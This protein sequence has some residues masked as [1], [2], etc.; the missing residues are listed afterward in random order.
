[1]LESFV[2]PTPQEAYKLAL[3]KYG[4]IENFKVVSAKQFKDKE[5][6]LLSEITIEVDEEIY[7]NSIGISQEEELIEEINILRAKMDK[8]K[9]ALMPQEQTLKESIALEEV[10]NILE[11]RGLQRAWIESMLDPFLGTQVAED[12]SLLISFILEEIEDALNIAKEPI[13]NKILMLVGPTGV[14][15]TTT[16]AKIAGWALQKGLDAN[17]AALIN[18]D[19][20]RVGAYEQLE[21]YSKALDIAY[22]TPEDKEQF[23][24]T[25][26]ILKNMDLILIDTAGSSPYDTKKLLSTVEFCKAIDSDFSNISATLV[27]SATSKYNDL[28]EA[29]KH[30]SFLDINK[31]II[32][33]VD[34]T[35]NIGNVIAFLIDT[36]LPVSFISSGQEVPKDFELATK[37][38]LLDI[39]IGEVN[40]Q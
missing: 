26:S 32:T 13:D 12:K 5:G 11:K 27:V 24:K 25:I 20:F 6:N 4:S 2:A 16:L 1:M 14:G 21:F 40:A 33:K 35:T 36:K 29:Y 7:K 28:M 34:E 8:M 3:Q 30:F 10:K 22:F 18:L 15:K 39:F 31:V 9:K 19:N 37:R 23:K 38:K 17:K